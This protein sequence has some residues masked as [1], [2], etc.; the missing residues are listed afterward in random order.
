MSI[1][2][3]KNDF[4]RAVEKVM[5]AVG[6]SGFRTPLQC[7][8][9]NK[10]Y[11]CA[12]DGLLYIQAFLEK[13]CDVVCS[14]FAEPLVNILKSIS[15][16][17]IDID[18]SGNVL[19][20]IG[21]N[22]SSDLSCVSDTEKF[23]NSSFYTNLD[24]NNTNNFSK[25]ILD[26]MAKV[27]PFVSKDV[28]QM[29]FCGVNINNNVYATNRYD[30]VKYEVEPYD[31]NFKN[32]TLPIKLVKLLVGIPVDNYNGVVV[33]NNHIKVY[34]VDN[35]FIYSMLLLDSYPS[36]EHKFNEADVNNNWVEL[37]FVSV[38]DVVNII[39]NHIQFQKSLTKDS[40]NISIQIQKNIATLCSQDAKFGCIKNEI[41]CNCDKDI[42]FNIN[43]IML[44]EALSDNAK[45]MFNSEMQT[46]KIKNEKF[47]YLSKV[48]TGI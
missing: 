24:T 45:I 36:F 35:V 1:K 21:S 37:N 22:T 17:F 8:H 14:V 46:I 30:L 39:N 40:K 23:L 27:I 9:I 25:D 41:P 33:E 31:N 28:N 19:K 29:A 44:K 18:L 6:G 10:N 16:E 3:N 15:D 26:G 12:L 11:V 4:L 47:N 5:P 32:I 34:C 38:V 7:I 43:P 42:K 2:I 48:I 13:S 20:I